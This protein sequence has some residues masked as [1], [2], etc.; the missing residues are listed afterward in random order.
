MELRKLFE[1]EKKESGRLKA[2]VEELD[3]IKSELLSEKSEF[4]RE[5][6]SNLFS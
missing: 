3:R 1:E 4:L 5:K 2:K 6:G